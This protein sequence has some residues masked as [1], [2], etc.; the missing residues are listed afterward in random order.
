MM[1][2]GMLTPQEFAL[3]G[4]Y[5]FPCNGKTPLVKWSEVSTTDL[6]TIELW[7]RKFPKCAWGVDCGKSGV[8]V[9]DDDRGKNKQAI[10]SLSALEIEYGELPR[11]FTVQTPSGGY[12]SYYYGEG[13]NSASTSLGK[14]L[15]SRGVGGFV[16]APCSPGY[17]IFEDHEIPEAP[18]W[19]LDLI[20]KPIERE[21]QPVPSNVDLDTELA[22]TRAIDYLT[23]AEPAI[24]GQ[25]GDAQ[26]YKV[27]CAVRDYGIS[28]SYC[29]ELMLCHWNNRCEPPWDPDQL[30]IKVSNAYAY[31]E[32][33]LGAKTPEAVFQPFTEPPQSSLFIEGN[34]L[35]RRQIKIDYLVHG[36]IE[37]P[38]T[39]LIFGD[40]SAGKSFLGV[41][42]A[43][44][45]A[46]GTSW[47]GRFARQGI[48]VYF[49]GEGR[50]GIQRR[51]EAWKRHYNIELPDNMIWVSE[52]RIEFSEKSLK[53]VANELRAIEHTTGRSIAACM[54]DTLARHMPSAADENSARDMGGFINAADWLRDQFNCVVAV[55]HHSGKMNKETSRGSSA[56]RGAMDWEF[57]VE[58]KGGARAVIFTKQKE[59]EVPPPFGFVLKQVELGS[60]TTSA[61]PIMCEYDPTNGKLSNLSSDAQLALS[62]LQFE[63]S[64]SQNPFLTEKEWQ[65]AFYESLGDDVSQATRRQK[66][67]RVKKALLRS[68]TIEYVGDKVFD[69]SLDARNDEE[70]SDEQDEA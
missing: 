30:A 22:M 34:A 2:E 58:N 56:I 12:H 4:F 13:R 16:V 67:G 46:C 69:L 15:D 18:A 25:G 63:I 38:S 19:F 44:A 33:P 48:T 50:Q 14:G 70:N 53:E 62:V 5:L 43:M 52:K 60:D 49:A 59:S 45:I 3:R 41:D 64:Q 57:K 10:D 9:L 36:L 27:A 8:V 1:P 17:T 55:V 42:M 51:M 61:V 26:T 35:L 29:Q 21:S 54:V 37:T 20:G 11:T 28:Q 7:A 31:A 32:T 39:G 24:E 23:I 40:P 65:K 66:F 47:M 68:V 6:S